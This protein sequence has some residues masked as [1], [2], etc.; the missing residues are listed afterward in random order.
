MTKL[1]N[2]I[3]LLLLSSTAFAESFVIKEI[4]VEG[5]QRL[6]V[7]TVFNYISLKAGDE[8]TD[9]DAKIIIR[10]LYKSKYF[11]DVAV[12]VEDGVLI[13]NVSERPAISSIEF[14]GNNDLGSEDLSRSL[15]EKYMPKS[16]KNNSM[17]KIDTPTVIKGTDT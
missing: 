2:I 5:L 7:G 17:K 1:L 15:R 4:R 11:N 12:E 13:I 9:N 14:V 3:I 16:Q 8:M 10:A 6:S